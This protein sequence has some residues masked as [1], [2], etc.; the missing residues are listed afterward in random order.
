MANPHPVYRITK[1]NARELQLKGAKVKKEKNLERKAFK[2]TLDILLTK[3]VK[4]GKLIS[5]EGVQSIAEAEKLNISAQEAMAIAMIQRA[6][7][8]DVNAFSTIRDTVGEK[9]SDKVELDQSLTIENYA[10]THKIKI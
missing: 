8:G 9:P 6:M 5:A 3:S 1:E 7:L 4:K 10:K 2:N